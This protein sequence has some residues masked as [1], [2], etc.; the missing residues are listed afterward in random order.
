MIPL[1]VLGVFVECASCGSTYDEAVLTMPTAAKMMDNLANAMRHAIVSIITADRVVD[2]NEKRVALE[3]M[4][5]FSDTPYLEW[6]LDRDLEQLERSKL[7]NEMSNVAG[8][9]NGHGK[10]RLLDACVKIAAADGSIDKAEIA[11][12]TLAG[13]ALGMS[14][15]H[16]KGVISLASIP[17][18]G[19]GTTD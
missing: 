15:A 3:V 17:L 1:D 8:M 14:P 19:E 16:I 18:L 13:V 11:E 5:E 9:L 12:V 7:A 6:D 2:R 4:E 10:E